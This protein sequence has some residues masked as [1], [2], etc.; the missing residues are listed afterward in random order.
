MYAIVSLL[1]TLDHL[2]VEELWNWLELDC[3]LSGVQATPIPHFSWMMMEECDVNS[4]IGIMG[5][6]ANHL[7]TFKAFTA[8]VGL[9][10]GQSP[11]LYL[12]IANN[13]S[14][15]RCHEALW[16]NTLPHITNPNLYY[17]PGHWF[18][19]VTLAYRDIDMVGLGCA[20]QG[21]MHRTLELDLIID[22]FA[23]AYYSE[24]DT[25]LIQK[26]VFTGNEGLP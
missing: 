22:H 15:L 9:F 19:H 26:F 21:L 25:G 12:P 18:P 20:V 16:H 3:G 5:D 13:H 4:A 24:T 17:A 11:V 14:M 8:G 1:N 10:T 6:I 2:K 23:L 7:Q